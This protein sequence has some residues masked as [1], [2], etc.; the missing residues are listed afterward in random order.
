MA[1]YSWILCYKYKN[2]SVWPLNDYRHLLSYYLSWAEARG[3]EKRTKPRTPY[4]ICGCKF[5]S[6]SL[7][8]LLLKTGI[9]AFDCLHWLVVQSGSNSADCFRQWLVTGEWRFYK[10]TFDEDDIRNGL[11]FISCVCN[12]VG[13][14]TIAFLWR[15]EPHNNCQDR[16][17]GV[18]GEEG[19]GIA[20]N[21][22]GVAVH[23]LRVLRRSLP[24]LLILWFVS[25]PVVA[26]ISLILRS[27]QA[28]SFT[29]FSELILD[30]LKRTR[31]GEFRLRGQLEFDQII[32]KFR[33][34]NG[35]V[36]C[37]RFYLAP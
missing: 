15:N 25:G 14:L 1:L 26:F 35:I 31:D 19:I 28:R 3:E 30:Y 8:G 5:I 7:N 36:A 33:I 6:Q 34:R 9:I 24:F 12:V 23:R 22:H 37:S 10:H 18:T 32:H 29:P 17:R 2:V 13:G 27:T 16:N 11:L 21:R 20:I 4:Y